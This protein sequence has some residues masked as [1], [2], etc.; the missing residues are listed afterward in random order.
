LKIETD[1][2][3]MQGIAVVL[4]I[5]SLLYDLTDSLKYFLSLTMS[6]LLESD[7]NTRQHGESQNRPIVILG[8]VLIAIPVIAFYTILLRNVLNIPFLDDYGAVLDLTNHTANL[9]PWNQFCY[10]LTSQHNEY[11]LIFEHGVLWFQFIFLKRIDFRILCVIGDSFVILIGVMLWKMFLP[12]K[13]LASR[14]MLFVPAAWLLFQLQYIETLNWAMASLQNLP[15]IA[16]SLV[17]IYLLGLRSPKALAA[18][19]LALMAA[20]ASSGNGLLV[21]PLGTLMLTLNRRYIHLAV[22]LSA[23]IACI[24]TYSYH[25]NAASSQSPLH[26]SILSAASHFNPLYPLSFMGNAAAVP[27]YGKDLGLATLLCPLIGLAFCV[28]FVLAAQKGLFSKNPT[29][30]FCLLF[31]LLTAIG[32]ACIRSELGLR[33]SLTSRYGIYSALL[34]ICTWFLIAEQRYDLAEP[35]SILRCRLWQGIVAS[36]IVFSVLMD[37][38][39]YHYLANRNEELVQGMTSYQLSGSKIG[40]I[41]PSPTQPP[42]FAEFRKAAAAILLESQRRGIYNKY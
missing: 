38:G 42:H 18:S 20:V 22:W 13:D 12:S 35:Q 17:A 8:M 41:L 21:I 14:L 29:I 23:S 1:L 6:S 40:P 39:G 19:I 11:K 2:L 3:L 30:Y 28:F 31:L 32:V 25:Y 24:G 34:L 36:S 10:L 4:I 9:S 7:H 27:L 26:R 33:Q 16:F 37:V 15:V 5:G